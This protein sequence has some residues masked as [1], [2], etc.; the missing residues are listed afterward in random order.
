MEQFVDFCILCGCDYTC[1][2]P[3]LGSE[4]A[5][6]YIKEHGKIETIIDIYCGEGKKFRL[7]TNFEYQKARD[8][9]LT[10]NNLAEV[11]IENESFKRPDVLNMN[12]DISFMENLTSFSKKQLVNRLNKI[13]V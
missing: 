3:K 2:I 9:I 1:K 8:L 4:T 10:N 13:M 12:D 11:T 7:P 6:K 5:F